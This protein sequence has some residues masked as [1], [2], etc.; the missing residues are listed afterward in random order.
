M[1][2]AIMFA[3]RRSGLVVLGAAAVML[4]VFFAFSISQIVI[5]AELGLGLC[6]S[7]LIDATLITLVMSPATMK[8]LGR[9]FWWW[10][11][12]LNWVPDLR[13]KPASEEIDSDGVR[14][15]VP[16]GIGYSPDAPAPAQTNWP[17]G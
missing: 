13:A 12:W 9:W 5:V 15:T 14:Q 3:F 4:V 1:S 2:E 17:A 6:V 10:P 7:L 16:E 8:L 11:R